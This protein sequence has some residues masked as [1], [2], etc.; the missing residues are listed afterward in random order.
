LDSLQSFLK[1]QGDVEKKWGT[2]LQKATLEL[3][4]DTCLD[5]SNEQ[6]LRYSKTIGEIHLKISNDLSVTYYKD[7]KDY[8]SNVRKLLLGVNFPSKPSMIKMKKN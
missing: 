2:Q 4:L 3:G 7:I 5:K 6:L 1:S 8:N